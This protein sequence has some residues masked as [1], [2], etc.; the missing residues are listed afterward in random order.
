MSVQNEQNISNRHITTES[1][2][3]IVDDGKVYNVAYDAAD[4]LSTRRKYKAKVL[5]NEG[6]AYVFWYGFFTHG[7]AA[8]A[9]L[10]SIMPSGWELSG[11]WSLQR[12]LFIPCGRCLP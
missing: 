5:V 6:F 7:A 9:D 2:K 1:E 4:I 8:V 11:N 10:A 3:L 12:P